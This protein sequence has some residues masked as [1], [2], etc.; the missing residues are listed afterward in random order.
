M[1]KGTGTGRGGFG[2]IGK[3]FNGFGVGGIV[4]ILFA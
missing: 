3:G 4:A 1:V 2:G